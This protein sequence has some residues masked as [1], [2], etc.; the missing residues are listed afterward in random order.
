MPPRNYSVLIVGLD[1]ATYDLMLPWIEEGHL[2]H[3][4][5]L[6]RGGAH[7]RLRSTIPPITRRSIAP[8]PF[9]KSF[10]RSLSFRYWKVP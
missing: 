9:T 4:A 1:G 5:G 10:V 3:L 8:M 2:P 7:S 6:L